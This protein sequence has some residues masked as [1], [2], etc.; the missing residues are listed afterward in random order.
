MT[1]G[2]WSNELLNILTE[3]F[4]ESRNPFV[5]QAV[6]YAVATAYATFDKSKDELLHKLLLQGNVW[7]VLCFFIHW[8][9]KQFY[10]FNNLIF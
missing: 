1:R 7:Y 5:E 9:I 2:A 6:Q 10:S 4:S 8:T 3:N